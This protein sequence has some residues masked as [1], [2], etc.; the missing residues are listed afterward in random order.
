MDSKVL[1][2]AVADVVLHDG[3]LYGRLRGDLPVGTKLYTAPAAVPA[4]EAVAHTD[5]VEGWSGLTLAVIG[6]RHFGNPIPQAWY[7]AADDLLGR[8]KRTPPAPVQAAPQ[9]GEAKR[10]IAL[11]DAEISYN[12]NRVVGGRWSVELDEA[13]KIAVALAANPSA[14]ELGAA[15]ELGPLTLRR[16]DDG[17]LQ[18]Y[19]VGFAL[20][21]ATF[22]PGVL[23]S[24]RCAV[25]AALQH[26]GDSRG[27][28]G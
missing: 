19:R 7:A 26:R 28:E 15:G 10:L 11:I 21:F 23:E 13:R 12:R 2:E 14:C 17:K 5:V 1:D 4:G 27:G 22:S 25:F 20:R 6:H 18:L 24:E 9:E 3:L 8:V 16:D